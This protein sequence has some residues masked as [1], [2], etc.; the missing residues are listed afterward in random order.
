MAGNALFSAFLGCHGARGVNAV[1]HLSRFGQHC[2]HIVVHIGESAGDENVPIFAVSA[3]AQAADLQGRKQGNVLGQHAEFALN[4]WA[5]GHF[6][7]AADHGFVRR[8]HF[9]LQRAHRYSFAPDIRRWPGS[10]RALCKA[11]PRTSKR[12]D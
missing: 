2:E 8:N 7:F 9:K 1:R 5:D 6:H 12:C 3:V 11:R 10:G 4:S